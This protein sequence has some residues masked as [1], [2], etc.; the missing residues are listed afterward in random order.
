MA[1][2]YILSDED[3]LRKRDRLFAEIDQMGIVHNQDGSMQ[4]S[5]PEQKS[6]EWPEYMSQYECVPRDYER[7]VRCRD[8]KH[9]KTKY[10]TM[11][12]WREDITIY[13]AKPDDF[14]SRGVCKEET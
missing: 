2:K 13:R 7:V 6:E 1:K 14:C 8:C 3:D 5:L 9:Y 11:D 4:I 12:I 10:C